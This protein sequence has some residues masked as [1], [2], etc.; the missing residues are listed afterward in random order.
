MSLFKLM[1]SY[2][3]YSNVSGDQKTFYDEAKNGSRK[4]ARTLLNI[5]RDYEYE[6]VEVEYMRIVEEEE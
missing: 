5:R 6:A 1:D 2:G 4:A 3:Y